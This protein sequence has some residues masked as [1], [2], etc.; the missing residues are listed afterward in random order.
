MLYQLKYLKNYSNMRILDNLFGVRNNHMF[1][2][3]LH[4]GAILLDVRTEEE[5]DADHVEGSVNIPMSQIVEEISKL[6]KDDII[7]AVCE[8]GGR[9]EQVV[10][11]LNKKGYKSYNGG[12]W[13][14]FL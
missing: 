11:Y 13:R 7:I 2:E 5:F 12:S 14:S 8:S 9:S 10:K 3:K 4:N 6:S 1:K